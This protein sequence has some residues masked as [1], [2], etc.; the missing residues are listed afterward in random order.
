MHTARRESIARTVCCGCAIGLMLRI[1]FVSS[2]YRVFTRYRDARAFTVTVV[3]VN[4]YEIL[5]ESVNEMATMMQLHKGYTFLRFV[6][7][8][9]FLNTTC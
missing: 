5:N 3:H 2:L 8:P 6:G 1:N 4:F 7:Q 9:L